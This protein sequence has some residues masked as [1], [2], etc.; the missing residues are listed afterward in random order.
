MGTQFAVSAAVIYMARLENPLLSAEGPLFYS[1]FIDDIFFIWHG[2]L[3]ELQ[4]FLDLLNSLAPSIKLT[5]SFSQ[6][7]INFV[8]MVVYVDQ[9]SPTKLCVKPYQKP[10]NRY[11]YIPF[12]SYHPNHAK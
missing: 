7:N 5:W 2:S 6:E 3:S 12:N 9:E 1:R 8:D 10:L 11:L 4:S